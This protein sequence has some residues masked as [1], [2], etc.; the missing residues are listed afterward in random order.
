MRSLETQPLL[1]INTTHF[2]DEQEDGEREQFLFELLHIYLKIFNIIALGAMPIF[3]PSL[4]LPV[5]CYS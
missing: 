3:L 1:A 2:G 4:L 5:Y